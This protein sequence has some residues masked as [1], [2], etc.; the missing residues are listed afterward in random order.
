MAASDWSR[1]QASASAAQTTHY[2]PP[3]RVRRTGAITLGQVKQY[4]TN[5]PGA[6]ASGQCTT[7][8]VGWMQGLHEAQMRRLSRAQVLLDTIDG[9]SNKSHEQAPLSDKALSDKEEASDE[10]RPHTPPTAAKVSHKTFVK[11][12]GYAPAKAAP[13]QPSSKW[14]STPLNTPRTV[15]LSTRPA[16]APPSMRRLHACSRKEEGSPNEAITKFVPADAAVR[17]VIATG[18]LPADGS[19]L[20]PMALLSRLK[21][22]VASASQTHAAVDVGWTR[23]ATPRCGAWNSNDRSSA[24]SPRRLRRPPSRSESR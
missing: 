11:T 18:K 24:P 13:A 8:E 10:S 6:M 17:D 19:A 3:P 21:H 22:H 4:L 7:Q 12:L 9:V 1:R 5:I 15:C 20:Q 14:W 2:V 23:S 16:S